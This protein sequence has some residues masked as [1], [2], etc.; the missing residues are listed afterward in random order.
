MKLKL[1][2]QIGA[3]QQLTNIVQQIFE[4]AQWIGYTFFLP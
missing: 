4:N 1:V 2:Q 3:P